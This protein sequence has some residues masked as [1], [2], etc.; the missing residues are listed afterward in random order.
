MAITAK[1]KVALLAVFC[2]TYGVLAQSIT[3]SAG[4]SVYE[5]MTG[6]ISAQ[7]TVVAGRVGLVRLRDDASGH[8]VMF[9]EPFLIGMRDGTQISASTL[10]ITRPLLEGELHRQ[11][12]LCGSGQ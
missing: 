4:G 10:R 6:R 3:S 2:L 7:V 12:H 9:R 11:A 1:R 8:A 5:V